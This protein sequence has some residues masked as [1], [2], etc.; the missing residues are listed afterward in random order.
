MMMSE[1]CK[2]II[3]DT[4]DQL[5]TYKE[6]HDFIGGNVEI[7]SLKSGD[8]LLVNED[9]IRLALPFNDKASKIYQHEWSHL[10]NPKGKPIPIAPNIFAQETEFKIRGNVVLIRKQ[11]NKRVFK[12][13][14]AD[15]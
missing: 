1:D 10:S 3:V 8:L 13:E 15:E 14:V 12:D 7:V 6:V 11:W 2:L 9:G 5:M 4:E